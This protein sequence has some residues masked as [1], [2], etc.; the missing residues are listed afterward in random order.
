MEMDIRKRFFDRPVRT[1]ISA[2]ILVI[3]VVTSA[4]HLLFFP[5]QHRSQVLDRMRNKG[6]SIT[7]ILAYNLSSILSFDDG[8]EIR[9]MVEGAFQDKDLS[10]VRIVRSEYND[11]L[12][13]YPKSS[14][15]AE[16]RPFSLP[17]EGEGQVSVDDDHLYVIGPVKRG[18]RTL[19]MLTLGFRLDHLQAE[20]AKRRKLIICLNLLLLLV[21]IGVA[22]YLSGLF[23][24]PIRKIARAADQL[25]E[26]KWGIQV[27]IEHSDEI[28]VLGTIF[29]RM[30]ESLKESKEKLEEYSKT[31]KQKVENRTAELS[32][33]NDELAANEATITKMLK[34]LN[35]VNRELSQTKSQLE[36]IFKSVVDRAI[37]TIN[38]QG[39][40]SFYSKSSELIFGY[41]AG[42]VVGRKWIQEFFAR[43][44]DYVFILLEH[45]REAGIYKGEAELIRRSK[46]VFPAIITI[47]PLKNKEGNFTGYTIMVEDITEKKKTEENIRLLSQAVESATDGVVVLDLNGKVVFVNRSEAQMHGYKP[48]EMIGRFQKDFYPES[49]W[50]VV[51]Q[52]IQQIYM[53]G[54]WAGELEEPRKDG[55]TF[56]VQI[57]AS[58]IK[59]PQGRPVGILSIGNDISEKKKMEQKILQS[60]RELFALNT[61]ASTVSQTLKLQEILDRSLETIL[62]LTDSVTGWVFLVNREH[63]NRMMLVAQSGQ[64]RKLTEEEQKV[65]QAECLC[66]EVVKSQQPKI[67]HGGNCPYF[68]SCMFR[69]EKVTCHVS[70][71]LRSKDEVLGVVN[72]GWEQEKDFTKRELR[73]LSSVG[74]EIGIAVDNALLFEDIQIAKD[75]LQK[76]NQK[77]EEANKIKGEF[78]ANT[79][80]ELRT[81]LNSIIGFLGLILDGYCVD[82]KEKEEFLRNAQQSAKHL[83]TIINDVLD[84]AKIEA[85]QMELELGEV[86]LSSMF[87]EVRSLAQVQVQQKKLKLSFVHQNHP[88]PKVNADAGKLRQVLINL[89]GNAIKF[90]DSGQVTVTSVVQEEKG[91]VLI[92][93][94]DSGIG[95]TS[96]MQEKLFEKFRQA[97]GSSTRKHGGTGLGLTITKNL[98]EMMGGA[99]RL[100][101]PGKGKG[102]K[103]SFTAPIH[104]ESKNGVSLHREQEISEIGGNEE[105]PKALIVEDDPLF[106]SFLAELMQGEGFATILAKNADDAVSL[107]KDLNPQIILL[108]FSLPQKLGGRLKDGKQVLQIMGKDSVTKDIPIILITGQDMDLVTKALSTAELDLIPPV[109]SKPVDTET[110][111]KNIRSFSSEM[112]EEQL[113]EV[114]R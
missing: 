49:Y 20:I 37:I 24:K 16:W 25:T 6:E 97:D 93:V 12:F 73:F 27:P 84:L 72:L 111:L 102:T 66:W 81:P 109:F 33:V 57:S 22:N 14:T 55:S 30:S 58:L 95:V 29:N 69:G 17:V 98:V 34:D 11:T 31:L 101:S 61:I 10:F 63:R 18:E 114:S 88:S 90:T 110:L 45:T 23:T 42:E 91:N 75:K 86:D 56:P 8:R 76:L 52:V 68:E 80:H 65:S 32:K 40:I 105:K 44:N 54:G 106:S 113:E 83:L 62:E 59:D 26:G 13:F 53:E 1:K 7:R 50:S 89:V 70:I 108:D 64:H 71:P 48:Y 112:K 74:N 79:S 36:N 2:V 35:V 103:I 107:A 28:G 104:R 43:N 38:T 78:L 87:E 9:V 96:E 99:I 47:T 67:L 46:Q 4:F 21:G 3:L 77:L 60:N 41:E 15:G 82:E 100:E 39:T 94:E 5:V 92:E 19:G 85:G 51:S